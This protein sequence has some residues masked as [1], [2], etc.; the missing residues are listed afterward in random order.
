MKLRDILSPS[1]RDYRRPHTP[2]VVVATDS[3]FCRETVDSGVL[4]AEQMAH[5]AARYRLGKSKSGRCIFWMIDEAGK[6]R[7]GRIGN[8]WVSAMM[9]AR[10]PVLLKECRTVHCLYGLHLVHTENNGHTESTDSAERVITNTNHTNS[11]NIKG[12][13]DLT[14][15]TESNTIDT[16][17]KGHTESTER[18]ITNTNNTNNTNI[19]GRTDLTDHTDNNTTDSRGKSVCIVDDE[20]AAVILSEL[21]P[22]C[23]WMAAMYPLNMNV[24]QLEPLRGR[25]VVLYPHT[26]STMSHYVCWLEIAETARQRLHMDVTCNRLLEDY[27]TEEQKGRE[28]DLVGFL[29][30]H[31]EV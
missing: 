24:R 22:E 9:E 7:D 27:A 11:T 20:R 4:T 18:V 8:E 26:D 21:F 1:F 31:T 29:T 23:L 16:R 5:A 3:D 19:K 14:D 30:E 28:I 25:H 10:E 17:I 15:L 13:T 12:R 2:L 6:V